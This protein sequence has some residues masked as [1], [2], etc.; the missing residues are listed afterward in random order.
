MPSFA[1]WFRSRDAAKSKKFADQG[2]G[3]VAP[4]KPSWQEAWNRKEVAPEE[5]QELIHECTQ[6][7]KSRGELQSARSI[8]I[9][10]PLTHDSPRY[11]ISAPP[12][13]PWI[14]SCGFEELHPQFLQNAIRGDVAG[15]V[16]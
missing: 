6:E 5:V 11:A 16:S 10:V 13:P 8:L 14:G 4:T 1:R 9:N 15:Q 2:D 12:L 3:V 7:M